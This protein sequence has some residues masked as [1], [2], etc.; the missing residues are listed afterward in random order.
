MKENFKQLYYDMLKNIN[1]DKELPEQGMQT[2]P[3]FIVKLNEYFNTLEEEELS[4]IDTE[5]CAQMLYDIQPQCIADVYFIGFQFGIKMGQ[6]S[7]KV[8]VD[9]IKSAM[10][11]MVKDHISKINDAELTDNQLAMLTLN[12]FK[13]SAK[14]WIEHRSACETQEDVFQQDCEFARFIR[15]SVL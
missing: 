11:T 3:G 10:D 7:N 15:D 12:A 8:R 6:G 2:S 5:L 9:V 1:I 14:L 4:N 13:L